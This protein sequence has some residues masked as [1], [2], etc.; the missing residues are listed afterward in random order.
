[1]CFLSGLFSADKLGQFI[2]LII[3][4]FHYHDIKQNL[5]TKHTSA[6]GTLKTYPHKGDCFYTVR[7]FTKN[8]AKERRH[9]GSA[10]V[11]LFWTLYGRKTSSRGSLKNYFYLVFQ[12]SLVSIIKSRQF[13]NKYFES[14]WRKIYSATTKICI[15]KIFQFSPFGSQGED[16]DGVWGNDKCDLYSNNSQAA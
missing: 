14:K 10:F 5:Y 15:Q 7:I 6:T 1:M 9:S 4:T 3:P 12:S 16:R 8:S 2:M 11:I 13:E